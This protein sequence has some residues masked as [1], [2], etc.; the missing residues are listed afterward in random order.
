MAKRQHDGM[1][2]APTSDTWGGLLVETASSTVGVSDDFAFLQAIALA[3]AAITTVRS[4]TDPGIIDVASVVRLYLDIAESAGL[5][6]ATFRRAA[7]R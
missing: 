1:L 5:E 4:A 6:I 7:R 2:I 3:S